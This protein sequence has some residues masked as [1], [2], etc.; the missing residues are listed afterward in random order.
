MLGPA[1]G[2]S[3][4][5]AYK[6]GIAVVTS[7]PNMELKRDGIKHV[8]I[9]DIYKQLIEPLTKLY[10]QYSFHLL[11]EQKTVLENDY[12]NVKG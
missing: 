3:G 4:G 1:L 10:P 12:Q 11:S 7:G 5:T 2:T 8:F 6:G 9:N